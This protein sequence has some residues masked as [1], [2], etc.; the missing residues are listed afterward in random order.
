[1][2]DETEKYKRRDRVGCRRNV[3]PN[4][5]SEAETERCVR[6]NMGHARESVHRSDGPTTVTIVQRKSIHDGTS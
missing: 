5:S 4:I 6:Q 1:M 2:I 3:N